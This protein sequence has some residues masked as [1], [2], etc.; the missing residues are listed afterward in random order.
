GN[1]LKGQWRRTFQGRYDNLSRI[2]EVKVQPILAPTLEEYEQLHRLPLVKSPHYFYRGH[3][4]SWALVA[5]LLRVPKS[6]ILKK[7]RR[8]NRLEGIQRTNLEERLH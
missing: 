2:L 7:K 5:K 1:Y 3:Y 6:K 4:P 8:R